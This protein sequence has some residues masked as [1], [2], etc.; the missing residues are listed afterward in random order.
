MAKQIK[1]ELPPEDG[2]E[3][4]TAEQAAKMTGLT[5]IYCVRLALESQYTTFQRGK[6]CTRW[7]VKSEIA[8]WAELRQLYRDWIARHPSGG[9]PR[10][11][12]GIEKE[13]AA[14][15]FI[16]AG[17]AAEILGV[18][19]VTVYGLVHRGVLPC[20]QPRP[21]QKGSPLWFSRRAVEQAR[22][23]PARQKAQEAYRKR[24]DW[25]DRADEVRYSSGRRVRAKIPAAWLTTR[26]AATRLGVSPARLNMMRITGR[27]RGE[28]LMRKMKTLPYWYYPTWEV[29]NLL[30]DAQY[31]EWRERWRARNGRA[32]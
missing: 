14:R 4:V 17:A 23:D 19:L 31:M 13:L 11:T 16:R 29:D 12:E 5:R 2:R 30:E 1:G 26:E 20:Y 15:L 24:R 3:W 9:K 18:S 25:V 21:G 7:F 27:I 10:W 8:R 22:D 6:T 28:R 32:G